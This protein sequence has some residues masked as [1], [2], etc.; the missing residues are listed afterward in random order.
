M[1]QIENREQGNKFKSNH[2]N[3]LKYKYLNTPIKGQRWSD[4]IIKHDPTKCNHQEIYLRKG[5]D[6]GSK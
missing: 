3:Y 4:W 2:N 1:K 5:K 6:V